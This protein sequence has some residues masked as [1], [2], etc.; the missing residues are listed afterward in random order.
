MQELEIPVWN[1]AFY[2]DDD[3]RLFLYWGCSD[4]D[5]IYGVEVDYDNDFPFIGE[6]V[7]L[8]EQNPTEYG[9]E[10]PGYYTTLV[11]QPP[12]I[13]G[14]WMT[15]SNGIYYLQYSGPGTEL[16]SYA[17]AVYVSENPLGPFS[18][19]KHNPFFTNPRVLQQVP[20]T[21][22]CLPTHTVIMWHMGTITISQKHIFERRLGL[23][24]VFY[25]EDGTLYS[26]T[27]YGDYPLIMPDRKV[28][29]W[30]DIFPGWM[31][32][33]YNKNVEVS[34]AVDTLPA[35]YYQFQCTKRSLQMDRH[36]FCF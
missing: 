11:D 2:L 6:P 33:S 27:R 4:V 21:G 5:P 35:G 16:I 22:A 29:G 31:L 25:D 12:W 8:I 3:G 30:D 13:E 19:Q 1:P 32:L 26:I 34:S 9:W 28:D 18:L 7:V 20:V 36:I 10:V 24:P 17:D 15:K 14:A 23:Y